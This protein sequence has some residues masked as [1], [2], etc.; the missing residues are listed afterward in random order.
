MTLVCLMPIGTPCIT[1][2]P[3]SHFT[4]AFMQQLYHCIDAK[5]QPPYEVTYSNKRLLRHLKRMPA[6]KIKEA[7]LSAL[8]WGLASKDAVVCAPSDYRFIQ[9]ECDRLEDRMPLCRDREYAP[10]T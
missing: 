6:E 2:L 1:A 5:C 3:E 7:L 4:A 8:E 9:E 10:D